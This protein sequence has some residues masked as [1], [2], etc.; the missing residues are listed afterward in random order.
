MSYLELQQI[1]K[2]Y[3]KVPTLVDINLSIQQGEFVSLIGPSGV[4]KT[5]LFNILAGVELPDSGQVI[6]DKEDITG[7]TGLFSYMQ[8]KDLLLPFYTVLDNVTIPLRLK[9]EQT[10]EARERAMAHM[11]EFG[12]QGAEN[13]YPHQI[14]G[15]MKQRAALLRSYLYSEK[16][17]LL[18]EPVSALDS[19]TKSAMH[20][21]YKAI[22]KEHQS[23]TFFITHDVEE[24]LKLSDKIYVMSGPPGRI[25]EA[26]V[27]PHGD[28][29]FAQSPQFMEYKNMLLQMLQ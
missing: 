29:D 22:T 20:R 7:K 24:A 25:A 13:K 26:I 9:G 1:Q 14:S 12:L 23:T 19:I 2:S 28:E 27:L 5:T 10:K 8:Q 21:W 17:M 18:D 16:L 15:G 6:L 3:Q 11:D 4:G